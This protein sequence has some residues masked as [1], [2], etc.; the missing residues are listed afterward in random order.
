VQGFEG[1]SPHFIV[2]GSL[3][4]PPGVTAKADV[5]LLAGAPD[6]QPVTAILRP[7]T[8]VPLCGNVPTVELHGQR[9]DAETFV[10]PVTIDF[11]QTPCTAPVGGESKITL[12][13][14]KPVN[15]DYS[16]VLQPASRFAVSGGSGQ[17]PKASGGGLPG[18]LDL[19]ISWRDLG[20]FVGDVNED[21][22]V[23]L[24]GQKTTVKLHVESVG[25]IIDFDPDA[26]EFER[27]DSKSAT[28]KNSGNVPLCVTY[29]FTAQEGSFEIVQPSGVISAGG[30]RS[31]VRVKFST[32]NFVDHDAVVKMT[33]VACTGANAAA[34]ICGQLPTLPVH[35]K[36]KL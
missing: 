25:A 11:G 32:Q 15:I 6:V 20:G 36:R 28:A 19:T 30:G 5:K 26:L 21:L 31:S 29:G 4:L 22:I 33:P 2:G 13:N 9:V 8:S 27:N 3:L 14:Y 34:P 17:V 10:S 24:D 35:G 1:A 7:T 18:K 23:T 12:S 16:A